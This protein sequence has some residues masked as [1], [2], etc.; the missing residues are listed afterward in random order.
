MTQSTLLTQPNVLSARSARQGWLWL[1]SD[2]IV[3][4]TA[5]A[6]SSG[7]VGILIPVDGDWPVRLHAAQ[8]LC[9][10]LAGKRLEPWFT[11][12]RRIRIARALRADDARRAGATLRD[13]AV[14]HFGANRVADEPWKTSA[15]KAQTARLANYGRH[16]ART[17]YRQILRGRTASR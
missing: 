10:T 13:V 11:R 14:A 1:Q 4:N 9:D 7:P 6:G 8:R 15:L 2:I 12:Q 17:G 16:L 3:F 5:S